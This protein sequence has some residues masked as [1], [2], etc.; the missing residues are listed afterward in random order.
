MENEKNQIETVISHNDNEAI[1]VNKIGKRKSIKLKRFVFDFLWLYLVIRVF[2]T[3]IDLLLLIKYTQVN[4]I[5][6]LVVRILVLSAL[7]F[8]FWLRV[9][10]KIFW[11][12]VR[13]FLIH[14]LYPRALLFIKIL[15]WDIPKKLIN[16]LESN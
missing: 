8:L 13:D 12:N 7:F 15:Y 10:N 14:P 9:G 4:A 1:S 3:D 11:K 16:K 6:Y 2:V 5:S